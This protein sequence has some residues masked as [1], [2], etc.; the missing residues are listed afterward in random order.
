MAGPRTRDDTG[1]PFGR[2]LPATMVAVAVVVG[3]ALTLFTARIYNELQSL[4][5]TSRDNVQWSMAQLE[6]EYLVFQDAVHEANEGEMPLSAVRERF[7]I[8]YSRVELIASSDVFSTLTRTEENRDSL[9]AI[10][11]WL[12]ETIP[13]IDG[14]DPA[15]EAAL[16]EL[17]D[18]A[19]ALRQPIRRLSLEGV[20]LFAEAS[21]ERRAAFSALL[22]QTASIAA[23]LILLLG[24]LLALLLRQNRISTGRAEQLRLAAQRFEQTVNGSLNAIVV[25]DE[26]G[27]VVEF[28]PGAERTFGYSRNAA[29]GANIADL[30]VPPR[31]KAAHA[32]G[33]A[34]FR[35]TGGGNIIGKGRVEI[36]ALHADGH[37]FPVELA[38]ARTSGPDGVRIVA[39]MRDI[40]QRLAT[41]REL[42]EARDKA[43]GAARAKSQFLAVMS[44]E[45][46]TPLNGVLAVLDLLAETALDPKQRE[47]VKTATASGEILQ[48]HI[49]DVLDVTRIEAGRLTFQ[50]RPFDLAALI[51]EIVRINRPPAEA[52]SNVITFEA[53]DLPAGLVLA[54][55]HRIGQ[56]LLNLIG[57][58]VKFT[59][60]GRIAVV[61]PPRR[62]R[63]HGRDRRQRQRDRHER[64]RPRPDLRRFRDARPLLSAQGRRVRTRPFDLPPHRTAR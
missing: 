38:L 12:D 46:R 61:G 30:V 45:M 8:F 35:A 64:G 20:R 37:E 63:R 50:P 43:L 3:I 59:E 36:E 27:T 28:N 13:L 56:I 14:P 33:M 58:A 5:A 52:R 48:H 40:T 11:D 54:D 42:I 57:N 24:L 55:R 53:G 15:L 17:D 62:R 39:Y 16:P 23:V 51:E 49:D 32:A 34:R 2:R 7:D 47:Y 18:A 10:R 4:R 19:Q 21:D 22:Y 60:G 6:V 41:E 9:Q 29:L 25:A 26:D 44:H 31:H 1:G